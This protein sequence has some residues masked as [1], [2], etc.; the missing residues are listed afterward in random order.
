MF[1][2]LSYVKKDKKITL[3]HKPTRE[4]GRGAEESRGGRGGE[5]R[6]GRGRG[7]GGER[8]GE[9]RRGEER[10]GE[11]KRGEERG[12]KRVECEN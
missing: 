6:E 2:H 8:R 9:E 10:R 1:L 4:E 7:R 5:R 3:P 12:R 11:E